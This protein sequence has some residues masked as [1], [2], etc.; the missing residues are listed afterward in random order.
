MLD[1][2]YSFINKFILWLVVVY[3]LVYSLLVYFEDNKL[4]ILG[5]SFGFAILFFIEKKAS[6]YKLEKICSE[7]SE[8]LDSIINHSDCDI[9]TMTDDTLLSKLQFQTKKLTNILM[10]KNSQIKKDKDEVQALVSDIAHQLKTPMANV[11]IYC[12]LLEEKNL[13]E[14]DRAKY[15]GILIKSLNKLSFLIESLIKMSRLESG[16]I[17]LHCKDTSLNEVVL[18]GISGITTLCE[19][20]GINLEY[21]KVESV[22]CSL[23]YKWM[24]EAIS[25]ILEN[26][27]K[28]SFEDT[29]IHVSVE[30]YEL[31]ARVDIVNK[32]L[33]IE[34]KDYSKIFKRFYRCENVLDK[35]GIGIG[36][37]LSEKIIS[38]HGGYIKVS[39]KDDIVCFSLFLLNK[40]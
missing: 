37:Y 24:L 32:G 19:K 40:C 2:F 11:K 30:K 25:N 23:D 12:E 10:A 9:F 15:Y 22:V 21:K 20:K 14:E 1:R 33:S 13:S 27:V 39:C 38:L 29:V 36:L 18:N 35:E 8:M 5:A 17:E 34:E 3:F 26:A 16:V 31:F 28:Y 7:L 4:L 6:D